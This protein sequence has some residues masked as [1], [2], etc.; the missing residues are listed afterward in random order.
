MTVLKSRYKNDSHSPGKVQGT[1]LSQS[2]WQTSI[3]QPETEIKTE[4]N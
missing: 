1:C 2:A 3:G 4:R